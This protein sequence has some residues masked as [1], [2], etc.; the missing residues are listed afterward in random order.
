MEDRKDRKLKYV[1]MPGVFYGKAS[2]IKIACK[3]QI[4]ACERLAKHLVKKQAKNGKEFE[5]DEWLKDFVLKTAE[6]NDKTL[7]LLDYIHS[8]LK[9]VSNDAQVLIKGSEI[10][11]QLRDQSDTITTLIATRETLINNL[12]DLRRKNQGTA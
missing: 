6:L 5:Q 8:L 2:D 1:E 12:N 4:L 10:R 11:D 7:E 3:Q 9:D